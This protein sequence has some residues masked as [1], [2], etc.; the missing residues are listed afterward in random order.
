MFCMVL[1]KGQDELGKEFPMVHPSSVKNVANTVL[2]IP[3]DESSYTTGAE[4]TVD[5]GATAR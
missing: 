1:A 4:F 3:S 2:F 5:V